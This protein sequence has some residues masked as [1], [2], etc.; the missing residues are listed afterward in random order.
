[1][2]EKKHFIS[3]RLKLIQHFTLIQ[4]AHEKRT[5][6]EGL[7]KPDK[8]FIVSFLNA[9][10]FTLAWKDETFISCLLASDCLFRDGVGISFLLRLLG[11]KPG[12][13]MNG[14]DVTPEIICAFRGKNIVLYG[15]QEP[16]LAKAARVVED[17]GGKVVLKMDGFQPPASYVEAMAQTDAALVILA[18]GMPKQ[19]NVSISLAKRFDRPIVIVNGGAILDFLAGRY[20]RAPLILRR[21]RLEWLFR[22]IQEPHR[23]ARRYILGGALF[24]LYAS[25]LALT[26]RKN[27]T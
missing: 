17:M 10:A 1:M 3:E 19:E 4:N 12:I 6:M 13:N 15:T 5:W 25:R 9:H 16:W 14:S 27:T 21:L 7:T 24:L 8:P 2:S 22:L 20:P 11:L 26:A 18:M 23:L